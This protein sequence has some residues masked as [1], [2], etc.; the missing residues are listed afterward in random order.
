MSGMDNFKK[1]VAKKCEEWGVEPEH[2][3]FSQM[4]KGYYADYRPKYPHKTNGDFTVSE[5][6]ITGKRKIYGNLGSIIPTIE[7]L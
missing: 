2:M 4:Q 6:I 7:E 3:Y 5:D 1:F